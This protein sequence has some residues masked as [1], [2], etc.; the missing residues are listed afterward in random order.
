MAAPSCIPHTVAR[1]FATEVV[2]KL[3]EEQLRNFGITKDNKDEAI[4]AIRVL[5]EHHINGEPKKKD[6]MLQNVDG[7]VS[8]LVN[9]FTVVKV[10]KDQYEDAE[11]QYRHFLEDLEKQGIEGTSRIDSVEIPEDDALQEEA[12]KLEA[13][14]QSYN[15]VVSYK[16]E[17]YPD[18][19]KIKSISYILMEPEESEEAS[20]QEKAVNTIKNIQNLSKIE[21]KGSKGKL[22]YVSRDEEIPPGWHRTGRYLYDGKIIRAKSVS[23]DV[24]GDEEYTGPVLASH[25]GNSVDAVGR[26]VFNKTSKIYN[27]KNELVSDEELQEII[28]DDL[29][30]V[31]TVAGLKNL[32]KDFQ[33]LEEQLKEKW[34]DD[35]QIITEDIRFFAQ[36]AD[37]TW[38]QGKPDML[39][40][41]NEGVVHTLDFKTSKMTDIKGYMTI[42]HDE[43]EQQYHTGENYGKQISRYIRQQQSYGLNV[44]EQAYV[45]LVDT[46]YDGDTFIPYNYSNIIFIKFIEREEKAEGKAIKESIEQKVVL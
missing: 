4:E 23:K 13:F 25:I 18:G 46:W 30:G 2:N 17:M 33:K 11:S 7:F 27:D 22:D 43:N 19:K 40:V 45:I 3:S 37:G 28:D 16:K 1:Q 20:V 8:D 42:F 6:Q 24:H 44:E 15:K 26:M 10:P 9:H 39:V 34:G 12:I 29:R 31:F 32:I 14:L 36:Q 21:I 41:D 5:V 35:I 38:I